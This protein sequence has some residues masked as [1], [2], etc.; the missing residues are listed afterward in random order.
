MQP[1]WTG[2]FTFIV[3]GR[4]AHAG[5]D[6]AAGRTA[7]A[8]LAEAVLRINAVPGRMEAVGV[9]VGQITVAF[10]GKQFGQ[11]PIDVLLRCDHIGHP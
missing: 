9:N 4:S 3:R 1:H 7:I 6:I 2:N 5:R 11:L 8:A 10:L